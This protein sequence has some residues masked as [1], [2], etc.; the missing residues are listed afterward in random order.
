MQGECKGRSPLLDRTVIT[1]RYLLINLFGSQLENKQTEV[2]VYSTHHSW[3]RRIL[4][5]DEIG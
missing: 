4:S 2:D 3:L 5:S 1:A